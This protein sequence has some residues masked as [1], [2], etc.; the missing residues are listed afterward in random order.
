[1]FGGT[2]VVTVS[3]SNGCTASTTAPV[4]AK[5]VIPPSNLYP[6]AL[7]QKTLAGVVVGALL[8]NICNGVQ[9][10][11]FGWLTWAVRASPRW[12]PA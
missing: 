4:L 1:V 12:L 6:I 3:H 8:P 7:S 10:G 5:P 2:Y 9:P 11:N